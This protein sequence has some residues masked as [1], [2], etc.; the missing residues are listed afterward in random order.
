VPIARR[1]P[2]PA[3]IE[4]DRGKALVARGI[5]AVRPQ[6]LKPDQVDDQPARWRNAALDIHGKQL[7]EILLPIGGVRDHHFLVEPAYLLAGL[8][9]L[10]AVEPVEDHANR[11]PT[12]ADAANEQAH[13][14]NEPDKLFVMENSVDGKASES[15]AESD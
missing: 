13:H 1:N 6:A 2:R 9:P 5:V 12:D 8:A 10:T 7:G 15:N 3:G 14:F 11:E 4:D